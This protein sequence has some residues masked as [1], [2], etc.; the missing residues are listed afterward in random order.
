M[1]I[2]IDVDDQLM[3]KLVLTGIVASCMDTQILL[4]LILVYSILSSYKQPLP[5]IR[6]ERDL[7]D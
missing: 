7:K 3:V 5:C 6:D 4:I 2:N 1:K